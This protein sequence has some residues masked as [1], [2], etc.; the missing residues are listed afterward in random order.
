MLVEVVV[1]DFVARAALEQQNDDALREDLLLLLLLLLLLS[2]LWRR[3]WLWL[4]RE[5]IARDLTQR[6]Q[7]AKM[8][9][10]KTA[11]RLCGC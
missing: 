4:W 5:Q 1:R 10:R 9:R 6:R 8:Q 2:H 7:D 3:L 11:T